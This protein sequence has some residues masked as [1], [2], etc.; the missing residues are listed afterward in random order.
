MGEHFSEFFSVISFFYDGQTRINMLSSIFN[1]N[2]DMFQNSFHVS[3]K[4]PSERDIIKLLE[5][6]YNA[7]FQQKNIEFTLFF[8]AFKESW[9]CL[10]SMYEI[11]HKK[12]FET[13][14]NVFILKIKYLLF[15]IHRQ[16]SIG[17]TLIHSFLIIKCLSC[18]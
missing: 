2:L 15:L 12:S 11:I 13:F 8:N 7:H 1:K 5:I 18:D 6:S 3:N 17:K 10:I 4:L 16:M 9:F 14:V